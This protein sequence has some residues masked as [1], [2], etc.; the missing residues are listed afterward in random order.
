[1]VRLRAAQMALAMLRWRL[2]GVEAP[3]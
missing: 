1:M 3:V 2:L